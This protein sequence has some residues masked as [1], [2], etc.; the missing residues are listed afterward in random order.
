MVDC[1][2]FLHYFPA[3]IT[4]FLVGHSHVI[5]SNVNKFTTQL[6]IK[7]L[8]RISSLEIKGRIGKRLQL[9][10]LIS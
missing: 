8:N 10:N 5:S 2:I 3:E 6:D 1:A 4:K 7:I 9:S